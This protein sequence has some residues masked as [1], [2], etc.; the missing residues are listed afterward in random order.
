ME[1]NIT[2][3]IEKARE[4]YNSNNESLKEIA[5][6]AFDE[7]ELELKPFERIKTFQ[8]ACEILD[9]DY[10]TLSDQSNEIK[11]ISK[12]TAAMFELN[13]IRKALNKDYELSLT[14]NS[15]NSKI[16]F[17][18]NP[19]IAST[20]KYYEDELDKGIMKVIGLI[21]N[22]GKL[23]YVL[24]GTAYPNTGGGLINFIYSTGAGVANPSMG[25]LGCANK[26]IAEHFGKYFGMLITKAK[27]GDLKDFEIINHW[28]F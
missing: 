17:P 25:F 4:W 22:K 5:L 15:N 11:R 12:A 2:I 28:Q 1:R 6:Q 14:E 16:Y 9:L 27:Y 21:T 20:S 23:Y 3:S 13:I 10:N 24:A 18:F 19:I 7:K 26:E 8:N